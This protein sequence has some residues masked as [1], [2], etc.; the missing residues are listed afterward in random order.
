MAHQAS[1][2]CMLAYSVPGLYQYL[3]LKYTALSWNS[4]RQIIQTD[5][6]AKW[7]LTVLVTFSIC[8]PIEGFLA[9]KTLVNISF[10]LTWLQV[11]FA[12]LFALRDKSLIE[13]K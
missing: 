5:Y 7:D 11:H 10:N 1:L 3:F 4:I 12:M 8:C 9:S 2:R 6:V 13:V